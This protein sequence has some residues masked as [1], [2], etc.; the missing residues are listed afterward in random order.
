MGMGL[1]RVQAKV[2]LSLFY[3]KQATIRGISQKSEVSRQ[4]IYRTLKTLETTGLVEKI[5]AIPVVYR[6]IPI[7]E[8]ISLL[9]QRR[10][11]ELKD[12][13]KKTYKMVQDI[14]GNSTINPFL[15]E[16]SEY[17]LIPSKNC[18]RRDCK[19]CL[20]RSS[21]EKTEKKMD[22]T[23]SL[24][25]FR[26][27]LLRSDYWHI[28]LERGAKLRFLINNDEK[29]N[30]RLNIGVFK[31]KGSFELRFIHEQALTTMTL[32]DSKKVFL[33]SGTNIDAPILLSRNP[34]LVNALQQYFE[35]LWTQ[36]SKN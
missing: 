7:K 32:I 27:Y 20:I 9:L 24:E 19:G 6:P 1:T 11:E 28:P 16:E 30:P 23:F 18:L 10:N 31:R 14:T 21:I 4:D 13:Q 29:E 35:F 26:K 3:M 22:A 15:E 5:I 34:C 2:Y 25:L 17:V 12:L 8:G 36:A 33:K